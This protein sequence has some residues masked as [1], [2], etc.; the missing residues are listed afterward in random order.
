MSDSVLRP[1]QQSVSAR[2]PAA[3]QQSAL[4]EQRNDQVDGTTIE[5]DGNA[6][7]PLTLLSCKDLWEPAFRKLEFE[8]SDLV[9]EYKKHI[10]SYLGR[11][12]IETTIHSS[13]EAIK[14]LVKD[15]MT[16]R[17]TKQWDVNVFR[18][19]IKIREQVEVLVG[20]LVK[21]DDVI[22]NAISSQPHLALAWSGVSIIL[23]VRLYQLPFGDCVLTIY[24]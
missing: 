11:E 19:R 10:S 23:P 24:S 5:Q 7:P 15:L 8:Q 3:S 20:L 1:G 21:S 12:L 14:G 2:L 6:S 4:C 13:P 16:K 22:K 17:E 9:A 18:H